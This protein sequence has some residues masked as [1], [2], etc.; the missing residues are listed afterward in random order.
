LVLDPAQPH[1]NE[2]INEG[3]EQK[4]ENTWNAPHHVENIAGGQQK[5]FFRRE[6][7]DTTPYKEHPSKEENELE[8]GENHGRLGNFLN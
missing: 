4:Q 3:N 6:V 2:I 8:R 1:P 5:P 7:P